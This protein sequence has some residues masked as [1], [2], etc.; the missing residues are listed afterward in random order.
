MIADI[1]FTE[2]LK[3]DLSG[4]GGGGIGTDIMHLIPVLQK[5]GCEVHVYQC[6][7]KPF[8]EDY[9]GAKVIGIPL[10]PGRDGSNEQVVK[11]FREVAAK[12]A[13][14][15]ERIEVF[16]ADFFSY[17]N[18]NPL[19]I[20]IQNGIAWDASLN[21]EGYAAKEVPAWRERITRW[22]NQ[23]RGLRR[24]E[25]CYNRVAIDLY[26]LNWYRSF[27]GP[28]YPG[29]VYYNPNPA[30]QAFWREDRT[31]RLAGSTVRIIMAR[32]M[33]PEKGTRLAA[34]I[35]RRLLDIRKNIEI[36]FAGEGPDK[37]FLEETFKAEPR[38][39]FI[40]FHP[41]HALE[42]HRGYDIAIIPS[43]CGEATCLAV[44]EAMAAGCAVV[45]T[46][47][48]GTIT[49]ILDGYNGLLCWPTEESLL[50]ALLILIDQPEKRLSMAKRGWETSQEVFSITLWNERWMAIIQEIVEGKESASRI[51]SQTW[52]PS[53]LE[54]LQHIRIGLKGKAGG[55]ETL[56]LM[57]QVGE[58]GKTKA[59]N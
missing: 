13:K 30:P 19:A 29:R 22:R 24:F 18:R 42:V 38:V 44:L 50:K 10:F 43:I 52:H 7:K 4:V 21:M 20:T 49:E 35:F 55:I 25:R 26:F 12:R 46:N 15:Q 8:L 45:A 9:C 1:F 37:S 39:T 34:R 59:H 27:R 2:F 16:A 54:R 3:Q 14:Q 11:V 31:T 53:I 32:R 17:W 57:K 33:V 6:G 40:V 56:E 47:M 58:S 48:G 5:C 41:H 28:D 36:T 23:E 51:I